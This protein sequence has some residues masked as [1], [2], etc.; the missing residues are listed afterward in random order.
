M[1]EVT[2]TKLKKAFRL[3]D[4]ERHLQESVPL[5][6]KKFTVLVN[7]KA[8]SSSYIPGRRFTFIQNT[9]YGKV[10]GEIVVAVR[11]SEIDATGIECRVNFVRDSDEFKLFYQVVKNQLQRALEEIK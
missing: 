9:I 8:I 6:A 3:S 10:E 7:N 2:L 1:L 11:S 5:R 4:I